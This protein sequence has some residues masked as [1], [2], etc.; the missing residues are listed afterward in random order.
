MKLAYKELVQLSYACSFLLSGPCD[1][2][3]DSEINWLERA[4]EKIKIERDRRQLVK[5]A[6]QARKG[7]QS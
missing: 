1:E 3:T 6:K 4:H 2:M 5:E 7:T